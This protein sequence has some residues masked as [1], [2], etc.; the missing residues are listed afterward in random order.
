MDFEQYNLGQPVDTGLLNQDFNSSPNVLQT[1]KAIKVGNSSETAIVLDPNKGFRAGYFVLDTKAL[2]RE[3]IYSVS[4][5]DGTVVAV[6]QTLGSAGQILTSTGPTTPPTFQTASSIPKVK[7]SD[8]FG[9]GA[10]IGQTVVNTGSFSF[11]TSGMVMNTGLTAASYARGDWTV[12]DGTGNAFL[13]RGSPIFTCSFTM[14][15]VPTDGSLFMG[16]GAIT[17]AGTGHTFTSAHI[18]AKVV[19]AGTIATLHF[20]QADGTTENAASVDVLVANDIIEMIAI[21]NGTTSVDYYY[22]KNGATSLVGPTTL[23]GNVPTSGVDLLRF[24]MAND[25]TAIQ[26]K[27]CINSFSYER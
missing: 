10:R 7:Y 6:P 21:V 8:N 17:V 15:V 13:F 4:D 20:T 24:S 27:G 1:A 19:C 25:N 11:G 22:R 2:T 26:F 12:G 16:I 5:F 18:G 23:T 14:Q 9:D 3:R